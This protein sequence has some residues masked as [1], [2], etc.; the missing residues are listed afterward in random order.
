MH[1]AAGDPIAAA[2]M[3]VPD[4]SVASITKLW[5]RWSDKGVFA[6]ED[7]DQGKRGS[8]WRSFYDKTV[9]RRF[10]REKRIIAFAQRLADA[11]GIETPDALTVCDR[12]FAESRRAIA[13]FEQKVS[14]MTDEEINGIEL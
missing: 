10:T 11:R 7:R 1:V 2:G 4:G 13:P 14:K 5:Q 6:L 9:K 8:T 12:L 3:Y